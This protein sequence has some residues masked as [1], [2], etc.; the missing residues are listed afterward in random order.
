MKPAWTLGAG[1]ALALLAS[2]GAPTSDRVSLTDLGISWQ[3][4]LNDSAPVASQ[5]PGFVLED[6][7]RAGLAPDPYTGTHEL[8]VQWVP[9]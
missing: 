6:L 9:V 1:L 7:V 3:V 2:C 8:D 5:V 4:G